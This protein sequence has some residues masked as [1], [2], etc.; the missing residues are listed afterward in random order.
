MDNEY[1]D[2]EEYKVSINRMTES[3]IAKYRAIGTDWLFQ[4]FDKD[5][6]DSDED[7]SLNIDPE[8]RSIIDNNNRF[9][10]IKS[11]FDHFDS[12]NC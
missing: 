12:E 6:T 1:S 8:Y 11:I 2:N 4:E 5:D 10:P 7:E 3:I 9:A